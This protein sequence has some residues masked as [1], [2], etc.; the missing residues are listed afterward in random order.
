MVGDSHIGVSVL[1]GRKDDADG[2]AFARYQQLGWT[3][4]LFGLS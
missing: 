1:I 2:E 3:K 4:A